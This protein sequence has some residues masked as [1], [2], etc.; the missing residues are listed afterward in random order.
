MSTI[1]APAPAATQDA[2]A[3]SPELQQPQWQNL[4]GMITA[5]RPEWPVEQVAYTIDR[6]RNLQT[7]P[8]LVTIAL[9]VAGM[10]VDGSPRFSKPS[11]IGMA[12]AGLIDL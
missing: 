6:C 5:I 9:R 7:F 4:F 1:T 2:P 10:R 12:V 3:S 8:N 11:Y